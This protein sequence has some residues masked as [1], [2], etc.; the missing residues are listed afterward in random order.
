[1][2]KQTIYANALLSDGKLLFWYTGRNKCDKYSFCKDFYYSGI[3]GNE[4]F[5]SHKME[6]SSICFSYEC[7]DDL[8]EVDIK[9]N[10]FCFNVL[11]K[12]FYRMFEISPDSKGEKP[13]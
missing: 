1:M 12:D 10:N 13:Y 4:Y 11:A 9:M 2:I 3:N 7:G 6:C 8:D 5:K